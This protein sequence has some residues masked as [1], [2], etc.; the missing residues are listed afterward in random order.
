MSTVDARRG[1]TAAPD[2]TSAGR[3]DSARLLVFSDGVIAIAITLLALGLPVPHG[4]DLDQLGRSIRHDSGHYLS[5][6]ISF[7]VIASLW[8][9]HHQVFQ[10]VDR[11]DRRLRHL[12]L[13]WLFFIVTIPFATDLLTAGGGSTRVVHAVLFSF[14]ALLEIVAGL[15]FL[16]MV[17]H[18]VAADLL[19]VDTP[20]QLSRVVDRHT[21][22]VLTGFT[23]SIPVLFLTTYG[24]VLWIIGPAVV[25]TAQRRIR[26]SAPDSGSGL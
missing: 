19:A 10:Y 18:A 22:G 25:G 2:A 13:A 12:S 4:H 6:L 5:F 15:I 9:V 3:S 21:V 1:T 16:A 20:P 26:P 8:N 24:W 14:Y 11:A 23:A 17:R 7:V